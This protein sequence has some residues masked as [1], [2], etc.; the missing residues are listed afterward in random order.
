M[1]VKN[2]TVKSLLEILT[3]KNRLHCCLS[4]HSKETSKTL[5]IRS[6]RNTK[7]NHGSQTVVIPTHF[8]SGRQTANF[9]GCKSVKQP[10]FAGCLLVHI[11]NISRTV[12]QVFY[13]KIKDLKYVKQYHYHRKLNSVWFTKQDSFA[14]TSAIF[15]YLIYNTRLNYREPEY[16]ETKF[17]VSSVQ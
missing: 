4:L 12:L 15:I 16:R 13:A 5:L 1:L 9:A 3:S 8:Y 11:Q 2:G 7:L 6:S 10:K 14:N 17:F